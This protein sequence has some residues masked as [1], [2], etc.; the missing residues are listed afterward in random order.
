[1]GYGQRTTRRRRAIVPDRLFIEVTVIYPEG[2]GSPP[3]SSSFMTAEEFVGYFDVMM[4]PEVWTRTP[5]M[6]RPRGLKP[7]CFPPAEWDEVLHTLGT[8][9]G[10]QVEK[11]PF[12]EE[13]F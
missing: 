12:D 2:R 7:T 6:W 11:L 10:L 8:R 4:D 3:S 9:H 13:P 1:M 5:F